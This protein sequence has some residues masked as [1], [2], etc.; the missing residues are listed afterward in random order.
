MMP[1]DAADQEVTR[2]QSTDRLLKV[3]IA[4]L[5][6]QKE[7]QIVSLKRQIEI[8]DDLGMRPVEI[9]ETLGR[10]PTYVNKELAGIRKQKKK[11]EG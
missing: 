5:L 6:R 3:I 9:A 8:L 2:P 1:K 11:R 7:E 4:L 10:T